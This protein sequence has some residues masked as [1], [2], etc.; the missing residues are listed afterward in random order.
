MELQFERFVSLKDKHALG[1][2]I[3]IRPFNRGVTVRIASGIDGRVTNSGT[4]HFHEAGKNRSDSR[5]M[6]YCTI[7]GESRVHVAQYMGH[8][9]YLDGKELNGIKVPVMKRR[10]AGMEAV[11]EIPEGQILTV[12]KLCSV[13]TSRDPEAAENEK[14]WKTTERGRQE[15][16]SYV[17]AGYDVLLQRSRKV[18]KNYWSK[19]DVIICGSSDFDQ[20]AVR[21][22]L[23]HLNIMTNREDDRVS[24]GSKGLSGDGH[25]GH[26]FWDT[27]E[28]ASRERIPRHTATVT[29]SRYHHP[30]TRIPALIHRTA[31]LPGTRNPRIRLSTMILLYKLLKI[32]A[33][34]CAI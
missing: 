11:V 16:I 1:F 21:F 29:A 19:N 28:K 17:E 18:W 12:D 14:L 15:A 26:Y 31:Y 13:F 32:M 9:L 27:G 25:E 22:A 7:T 33:E 20:L 6:E 4:Q 8:R 5:I 3:T 23:Y 30:G 10:Y 2:R 34:S 24:I